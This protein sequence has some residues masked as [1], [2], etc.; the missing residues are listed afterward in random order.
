M[1]S[2]KLQDRFW[3]IALPSS[4]LN[5]IMAINESTHNSS[6]NLFVDSPDLRCKHLRTS[7]FISALQPSNT[8]QESSILKSSSKRESIFW[9]PAKL[10]KSDRKKTYHSNKKC[11]LSS[12]T[13]AQNLCLPTLPRLLQG[14]C[15]LLESDAPQIPGAPGR[16]HP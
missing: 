14:I 13:K 2:L 8:N 12:K 1:L 3:D 5:L 15:F 9:K 4:K 11:K 16:L 6:I 10:S 7:W